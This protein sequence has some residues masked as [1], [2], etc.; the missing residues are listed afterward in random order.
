MPTLIRDLPFEP[1]DVEARLSDRIAPPGRVWLSPKYQREPW[2]EGRV[3]DRNLVVWLKR[4]RR[5]PPL[6]RAR[7]RI[8]DSAAGSR[9]TIEVPTRAA[10]PAAVLA[11]ALL[12]W[13][14]SGALFLA[15]FVG[16]ASIPWSSFVA[17]PFA[18]VAAA[19]LFMSLA[20]AEATELQRSPNAF[21]DDLESPSD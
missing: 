4:P 20:Q 3:S 6:A 11:F 17:G 7:G 12:G 5:G 14:V 1:A 16:A 8:T 13:M 18:V 15:H 10:I 9:I 2:I 19:G 21:L